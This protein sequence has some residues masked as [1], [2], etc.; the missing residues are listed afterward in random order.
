[1]R[2]W[3]WV[4]FAIF[5][6]VAGLVAA[7]LNGFLA[8]LVVHYTYTPTPQVAKGADVPADE[9]PM[10]GLALSG[11]GARAAVFAAAG[12]QALANR[13]ILPDVTHV[14]S[15]SGGGFAASFL[16]SQP[17]PD[18]AEQTTD[19]K[20]KTCFAP[21]F[22][23]M[24]EKMA[25]DYLWDTEKGQ[26]RFLKRLFSPS[27]RIQS[28]QE[29]L[30]Q[31]DYLRDKTFASITDGR[32]YFFNAV[33]YDTG[34]RFVF[35]NQAVAD[36]SVDQPHGLPSG[37]RS[38]SF[39]DP[40]GARPTPKDLKLSLAVATSAAFPPYL[41]P[42]T[43]QRTATDKLLQQFWHLGDGG[44]F[45]NT[46]VE[47]LREIV[48]AAPSPP[49]ATIYVFNAG[50]RLDKELS[51]NTHDISIW[52]RQVTRLVDVILEYAGGHR[53]A[54]ITELKEKSGV[55]IKEI[56]FDYL[57]IGTLVAENKV[58]G[59]EQWKEWSAW[60]DTCSW[61]QRWANDTPAER[62]AAIP[63]ALRITPCNASLLE[64]AAE[65]LVNQEFP[66]KPSEGQ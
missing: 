8:P 23:R 5:L 16:A 41:G 42:T 17:L 66:T 35:S 10:I 14:S 47:M 12:M 1:M 32:S 21:Y 57:A 40:S 22:E 65:F 45:E 56:T 62:L 46:G 44:V 63:T 27:H 51:S 52:S 39:S 43:I 53:E 54:L 61:W 64:A 50:Q 15:V 20:R 6:C 29:A 48:F 13:G 49:P 7:V 26:V 2:V 31:K 37:V 3:R 34:Q 60:S 38:L 59:L 28:L 18:C 9:A 30:E 25:H 19:A 24:Q 11:G 58:A 55:E 33:S 4:G 36:P